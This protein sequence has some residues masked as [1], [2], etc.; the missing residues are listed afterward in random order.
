MTKNPAKTIKTTDS[1]VNRL[2]L[3]DW[4]Y[5]KVNSGGPEVMIKNYYGDIYLKKKK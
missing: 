2:T 4:L 3:D 1:G 5:A